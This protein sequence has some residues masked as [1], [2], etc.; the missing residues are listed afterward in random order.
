MKQEKIVTAPE[1]ILF[2]I[3]IILIVFI[4][5]GVIKLKND[6]RKGEQQIKDY[7]EEIR[8]LKRQLLKEQQEGNN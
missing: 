7:Q 5:Y 6:L 8:V 4:G 3:I 1:K 2:S